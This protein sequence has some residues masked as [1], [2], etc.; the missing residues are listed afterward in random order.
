MKDNNQDRYAILEKI[1]ILPSNDS[2]KIYR[3][4][5]VDPMGGRRR[6][7]TIEDRSVVMENKFKDEENRY[8]N[9]VE[10]IE[11]KGK[12]AYGIF[13]FDDEKGG[14]FTIIGKGDEPFFKEKTIKVNTIRD[15]EISFGESVCR[16]ITNSMMRRCYNHK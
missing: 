7:T 14:R 13:E 4:Y 12:N 11:I 3:F 9:L 16:I 15:L 8:S 1:V 2:K 10:I 5:E 6:I